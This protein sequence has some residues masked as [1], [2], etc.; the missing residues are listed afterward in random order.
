MMSITHIGPRVLAVMVVLACI[1]SCAHGQVLAPE[2]S[3]QHFSTQPLQSFIIW[4]RRQGCCN[5]MC[6]FTGRVTRDACLHCPE[7]M[8]ASISRHVLHVMPCPAPR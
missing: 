7:C 6:G 5:R 1:S 8:E 2:A 3:P 4:L